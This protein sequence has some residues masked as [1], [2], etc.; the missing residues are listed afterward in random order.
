MSSYGGRGPTI[1][2]ILWSETAVAAIFGVAKIYTRKF[3]L[4]THGLDDLFLLLAWISQFKVDM[5]W[6][7][8]IAEDRNPRTRLVY[9]EENLYSK[10]H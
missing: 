8:W 1:N 10:R 6:V 3:I 5:I 7:R 2:V 9:H 4:G